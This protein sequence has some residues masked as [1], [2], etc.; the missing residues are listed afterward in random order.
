MNIIDFYNHFLALQIL[1]SY[2]TLL[3]QKGKLKLIL[4]INIYTELHINLEA[5]AATGSL[6]LVNERR[7]VNFGFNR[8]SKIKLRPQ[9]SPTH[10]FIQIEKLYGDLRN[11]LNFLL[12]VTN[13]YQAGS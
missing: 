7:E 2:P 3:E 11:F 5:V 1:D 13:S 6:V 8:L 4:Q 12:V 10:D 9:D